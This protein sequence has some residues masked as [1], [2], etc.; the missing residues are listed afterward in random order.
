MRF[1]GRVLVSFGEPVDVSSY[2]AAS[3]GPSRPFNGS[4][5]PAK[6]LHALTAGI[7]WAMEREVVDVERIDATALARAVEAIY[8]GEL[9][10][11]LWE[12]RGPSGRQLDSFEFPGRSLTRSNTSANRTRR[13]SSGS[14]SGFSV[15]TLDWP[16]TGSVTRRYGRA[17]RGRPSGSRSH[18][19]G[20]R[21]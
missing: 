2:L 9:E 18:D 20:R 5:I 7:Q 1:R 15:T 12:E 14:G 16:P 4:D 11:E 17:S 19:H 13:A 10:R 6:A 3:R 21:S 8:R